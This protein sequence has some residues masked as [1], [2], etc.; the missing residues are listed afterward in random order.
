M[1]IFDNCWKFLTM[2]AIFASC[3]YFDVVQVKPICA[4][5]HSLISHFPL[6]GQAA[7]PSQPHLF[8]RLTSVL[9]Q[10]LCEFIILGAFFSSEMV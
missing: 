1:R 7:P 8:P 6:Q 10:F 3:D 5:P 9:A 4:Q 2:L